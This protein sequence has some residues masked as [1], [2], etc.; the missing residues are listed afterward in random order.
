M[1]W[2]HTTF[3][4][5]GLLISSCTV[6]AQQLR[7]EIQFEWNSVKMPF[8]LSDMMANYWQG[9]NGDEDG[10]VI[11]TGGCNSLKGNERLSGIGEGGADLFACLSTSNATL[12]FDPFANTFQEMA[13]APHERQR[14]AAALMNGQVFVLGGRDSNDNLVTAIDSF[15]PKTNT[16]STRG[17]LP[18]DVVTSDLTAWAWK[19]FIYVTGGFAADYT[20]VGTAYRLDMS[21]AANDFESMGYEKM[22]TSPH[23]RGDI[24]AVELNGYAYLAGGLT[25]TSLWCEALDTTER[26]HMATDTWEDLADLAVGRADTAVAAMNGKIVSVGGE[27]KPDGCAELSDPAYGSFPADH[28]E[29]LLNPSAGKDA[30][31]VNFEKFTDQRFRFSAAVVPAQNRMYTFGGQLPFDFT[32]DCFPTSDLVGV[33]TEV[34]EPEDK[35]WSAAKIAGTAVGATLAAVLAALIL[36]QCCKKRQQRALNVE[37]KTELE[38]NEE[39]T[40]V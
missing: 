36:W 10:F 30:K 12:K 2:R 9:D 24:H 5:S 31:W 28:V 13:Q 33:G 14:H 3:W 38:A 18:D 21:S 34:F 7:D 29:V 32:C 4:L 6:T 35:S 17:Q 40:A 39:G 20:A 27:T 22:A 1:F 25:H 23:P 19:N 15:N 37:S 11:I 8:K 16:W 26:Y